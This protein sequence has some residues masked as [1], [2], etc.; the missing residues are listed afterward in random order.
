MDLWLDLSHLIRDFLSKKISFQSPPQENYQIQN[1]QN[2]QRVLD[3]LSEANVDQTD[4]SAGDI[5]S[6]HQSEEDS[7]IGNQNNANVD[8]TVGQL[9]LQNNEAIEEDD[10][11][12]LYS[13]PFEHLPYYHGE[14][15]R[16]VAEARLKNMLRGTFLTRYICNYPN[17][18]FISYLKS[19]F[20]KTQVQR[21]QRK[22]E[23]RPQLG[24][25]EQDDAQHRQGRGWRVLDQQDKVPLLPWPGG[26]LHEQTTH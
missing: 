3:E 4:E 22:R 21:Q 15:S 14:I 25:G 24:G 9:G 12:I 18:H 11:E 16:E 19:L 8:Q 23:V 7:V 10:D 20:L 1:F 17:A 13:D 5:L 2:D 6:T 26:A